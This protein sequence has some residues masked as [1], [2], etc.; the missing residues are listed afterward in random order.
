MV[1]KWKS[2]VGKDEKQNQ[3]LGPR[4]AHRDMTVEARLLN[5]EKFLEKHL[6]DNLMWYICDSDV[7]L[8]IFVLFNVFS[9]LRNFE[10]GNLTLAFIETV[11]KKGQTVMGKEQSLK[12]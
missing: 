9:K 7:I 1:E 6:M 5:S 12:L 2:E 10:S 3:G 8:F 4:Q 11:N